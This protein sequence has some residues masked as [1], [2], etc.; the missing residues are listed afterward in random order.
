MFM[1]S[2]GGGIKDYSELSVDDFSQDI[3]LRIIVKHVN[4]GEFDEEKYPNFFRV[5]EKGSSNENIDIT[6]KR[7]IQS[8]DITMEDDA[9]KHKASREAE[10]NGDG[11]MIMIDLEDD[12][13]DAVKGISSS[14]KNGGEGEIIVL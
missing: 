3:E 2:L 1:I 4:K 12:R 9:K 5:V 14:G 13:D 10:S 8:E 7:K 11:E 6:K